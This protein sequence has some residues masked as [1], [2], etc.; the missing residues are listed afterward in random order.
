MVAKRL[1]ILG[2]MLAAMAAAPASAQEGVPPLAGG[3]APNAAAVEGVAA[4]VN[5]EV[6]STIDVRNRAILLLASSGIEPTEQDLQRAEAQ[7]LRS[8]VDERL[9]LQEAREFEIT[10]EPREV[11]TRL[12]AIAEQNGATVDQLT[13]QLASIGVPISTLRTQIEA[14]IAW[15]RLVGGRYGPRVRISDGQVTETMSRIMS[16]AAKPQ[17]LVSE[18]VIPAENR[19][20]RIQARQTAEALLAQMR[21]GAPFPLV[22]RQFSAAPT[23]ASGGDLGWLAAGELRPELERAIEQLRPGQVSE[24]IDAPGGVYILALRER[25]AGVDMRA[26]T[27]FNLR[28]IIAPASA[29]EELER[30]RR[31]AAGCEGAERMASN[32]RGASL[33]DLGDVAQ[34][35]LSPEF[36][37]AIEN[38]EVGE[39]SPIM[40]MGE[41][42][43]MLIVCA[44]GAE[45]EGLPSADEVEDRLFEQELAMLSQRYLRNLRR[46]STIITP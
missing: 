37:A 23:A 14:D 15:Q 45:G 21:Q 19:E 12:E 18:I 25:R 7:A 9:Q 29:R 36:S 8:L 42:V 30:A 44:K 35:D 38:A 1:F 27:K 20:E 31:R 6:I 22:A 4:I 40:P 32:V 3:A 43:A 26:A 39:A 2:G 13:R 10:I 41:N 16:N 24:P 5:D 17:M 28:E 11:D 33:V 34:A 46:E